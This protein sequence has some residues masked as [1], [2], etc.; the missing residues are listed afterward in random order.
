MKVY[1][2][3][4]DKYLLDVLS[5]QRLKVSNID[6]L[7]DPYELNAVKSPDK[8]SREEAKKFKKY[9]AYRYCILCFSKV[10]RNPLLWSHYANRHKGIAI[11]FT[12][13]DSIALPIK[14]RKNRYVLNSNKD[15]KQN[16]SYN[17]RDIEGLW[18]TK[19]DGWRYEE[20][21]RIIEEK[22]NC[23]KDNGRLFKV[24]DHEIQ[25]TGLI[26]GPLCEVTLN[27]IEASLPKGKSISVIRSRLA[28]Q[29]FNIVQQKRFGK[30][31][32]NGKL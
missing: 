8:E 10:W 25:L 7:N 19:F 5:Q 15:N 12:I 24:F 17:K 21:I 22:K 30:K 13:K 27:A 29:S 1:H 16:T 26:L 32:I 18:L 20:E 4:S 2:F 11:E 14:Y 9:M 6:D 23:I 28:F 31:T 3:I